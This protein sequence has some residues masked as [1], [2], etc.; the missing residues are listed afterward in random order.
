[1]LSNAQG[2]LAFLTNIDARIVSA[3]RYYYS[4]EA[5]YRQ[6]E[7]KFVVRAEDEVIP[8]IKEF[9]VANYGHFLD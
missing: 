9:V 7:S 2:D 8:R 6:F 1:M 5:A 3:E 4:L